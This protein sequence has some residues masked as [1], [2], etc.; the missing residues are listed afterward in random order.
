MNDTT[1]SEIQM[2]EISKHIVNGKEIIEADFSNCNED[3]II[4]IL[5]QVRSI[6]RLGNKPVC[7]LGIFNDK[8]LLTPKV[9]H[10]FNEGRIDPSLLERQAVV[11]LPRV[12]K[13]IIKGHNVLQ[14]NSIRI[15][16]SREEAI[17]YLTE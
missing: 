9:M 10:Y 16:E 17:R 11:G 8:S 12:K 5:S 13:G 4:E 6:I 1:T 15:F 14:G 2:K 3:R 7:T